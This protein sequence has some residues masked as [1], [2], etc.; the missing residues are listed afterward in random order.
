MIAPFPGKR[1]T[2]AVVPRLIQT[3]EILWVWSDTNYPYLN[4]QNGKKFRGSKEK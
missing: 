2:G 3:H 4:F 1:I